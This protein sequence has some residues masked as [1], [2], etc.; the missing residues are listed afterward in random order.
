MNL[1]RG[2]TL[3]ELLAVIII[4][5]IVALIATPM[6]LDVIEDAKKSA[7][8]SEANMIL[9]G[10]NNYCETSAMEYQLSKKED[11]C[12]DGV[13]V[14][15]IKNMV[16]LG[17]ATV[18]KVT[19][20]NGKVTELEVESNGYLY[21]LQ[22]GIMVES[23]SVVDDSNSNYQVGDLLKVDVGGGQTQNIYV[24][25]TNGDTITGILDRNLGSTIAWMS[26]E[27]LIRIANEQ[28]F[29]L[30]NPTEEEAIEFIEVI[31]SKY[32]PI[33]AKQALQERTNTWTNASNIRIP[34]A[35]DLMKT[36]EFYSKLEDKNNWLLEYIKRIEDFIEQYIAD[37]NCVNFYECREEIIKLGYGDILFPEWLVKNMFGTG[38]DNVFAYWTTDVNFAT[39][40]N[41][42]DVAFW[43]A[44]QHLAGVLAPFSDSEAISN[45]Y[46]GIRPIITI[47][48]VNVIEKITDEVPETISF[49]EDSWETIAENV[50]NGNASVY[51]VG[52]TKEVTLTG[53]WAGTYTVRIANNSTPAECST[54]GFSQTACGFIVEFVDIITLH[55][56][57]SSFANQGGWPA[58]KMY[59]FI[60]TDIYNT[61]P[62]DLQNVI[63]NTY[64]VSGHGNQSGATNYTST[65]K[66]YL[67]STKE[68]WGSNPG[69][70]SA[71]EETRQ[72]DYYKNN[73][74]TI[75]SYSGA[76]KNY[77][78]SASYWWLRAAQS[79][80]DDNF[81]L[82]TPSGGSDFINS[83]FNV[84][85][86]PAFRI[87]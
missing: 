62:G 30:E 25:E 55:N 3:I 54:E 29:N 56:M 63:I 82:V 59:N 5:A 67:L 78:G 81:Y 16:N 13:T 21:I 48:E 7:G 66:L 46:A 45:N 23:S 41:K 83:T 50:K 32:G 70:D 34:S 72:L 37:F 17:N 79:N 49:T 68:V 35:L 10:I 24:L 39:I 12:A 40:D 77:Q 14:E 1:K 6:V 85:V 28:G 84:G 69:Y 33:T 74:V 52:D 58:S 76:R 38:D 75:S 73:G 42:S 20:E 9:G 57:N 51:N 18:N 71:T 19:Y 44:S 43:I 36:T 64:S 65:D 22:D 60:N 47:S 26:E 87:G 8:L 4:L 53:D 61:L 11:I 80:Y 2:F 86:A 27:E 31:N 15:E